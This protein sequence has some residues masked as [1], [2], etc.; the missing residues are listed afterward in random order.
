MT[1]MNEFEN[2]NDIPEPLRTLVM[3]IC[4]VIDS[5][6]AAVM[7]MKNMVKLPGMQFRKA[8]YFIHEG[9]K[10][11]SKLQ[12]AVASYGVKSVGEYPLVCFDNTVFGDAS[13]GALITSKGIY[14]K[15][16]M[17]ERVFV[18][19]SNVKSVELR[20]VFND[21]I[22]VNGYE[23]D[24]ALM[25]KKDRESFRNLLDWLTGK[26]N[27]PE[28]NQPRPISMETKKQYNTDELLIFL[29]NL[30]QSNRIFSFD[31]KIYY[32][33]S[34]EKSD[35]KIMGAINSYASSEENE[36]P[37]VC[38]DNT[39]F[40]SATE[41]CLITTRGVYVHN[42]MQKSVFF[43]FSFFIET[44]LRGMFAKDV[45]INDYEIDTS[46]LNNDEREGLSALI[47]CVYEYLM[48]DVVRQASAWCDEHD[49]E[50]R[51][52]EREEQVGEEQNFYEDIDACYAILGCTN[53]ASFEEVNK[54]YKNLI[55]Q[56]H[57]DNYAN[58]PAEFIELANRETKKFNVAYNCI[59]QRLKGNKG[60]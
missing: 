22:Y 59:K 25:E 20:G 33:G 21:E 45:Y 39:V 7:L 3:G 6:D 49:E 34:G 50:G 38:F 46:T 18:K 31:G 5:E 13:Q 27:N 19:F 16:P 4:Y 42:K 29:D 26:F 44:E 2:I 14:I 58:A 40:G 47:M 53:N 28:M 56:Y 51:E 23:I 57:P 1:R 60:R 15:N 24:S 37:L 52:Q 32:L 8:V 41:G 12:K 9:E 11:R 17:S 54:A 10:S 48:G 30:R 43:D 35:K 55:R 36:I